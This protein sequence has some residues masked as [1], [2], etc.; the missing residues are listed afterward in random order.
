[1]DVRIAAALALLL[2]SCGTGTI[3]APG[4]GTGGPGPVSNHPPVIT[5][6]ASPGSSPIIEGGTTLL[7]VTATDPDGDT[8]GYAWTQTAPASPQGSF[9]SR[10]VRN[11]TWTAPTVTDDTVFTFS[12]T[13]TDG[14]GGSV[15]QS[16]QVTVNHTTVNQPPVVSNIMVSPAMP[17]AGA[18]VTLSITATDPE[19]DPL[20]ITWTQTAPAQQGTFGTPAQASTSWFSPPLGVD[21][22]AFTFQVTVSDGHNPI[23][24]RQ[25][26]VTV[27]TPSYAGDVQ[28]LWT[29]QC[30]P[31][32]DATQLSGQLNL[33]AGA[34]YAALVNQ[35]MVA[36]CANGTR[37]VPGVPSTS[38][39]I[40]RL[41]GTSCGPQ[42]PQ[43]ANAL[44]AAQLVLIESWILRG[45]LDN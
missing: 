25:T 43:G 26:T 45:A 29:A 8:L 23:V 17:V 31:C 35:A 5:V 3:T 34:S 11:P 38:G 37:V 32:H 36:T 10:T 41:L 4:G 9:S 13:V 33:T 30:L 44:G 18:V 15:S 20:T 19:G 40:N 39:L 22:L 21:S 16:C 28:P 42:E 7:S 27:G 14:Q 24:Q 2:L 6:A 1:V 12:V